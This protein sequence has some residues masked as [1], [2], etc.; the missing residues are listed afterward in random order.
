M[1]VY[2]LN[3]PSKMMNFFDIESRVNQTILIMCPPWGG[4]E[5]LKQNTF[6]LMTNMTP[7]LYDILKKAFTISENLVI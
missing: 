1:K 5:Y 2:E 3:F 4:V 7:S 6:D